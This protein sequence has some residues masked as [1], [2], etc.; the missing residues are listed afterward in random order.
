METK[1]D[2]LRLD[3]TTLEAPDGFGWEITSYEDGTEI[4]YFETKDTSKP[5]TPQNRKV[6]DRMFITVG[7]DEEVFENALRLR[8]QNS[9]YKVDKK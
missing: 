4:I 2:L 7:Y 3:K 6:K 1:T 8:K 5:S 9:D